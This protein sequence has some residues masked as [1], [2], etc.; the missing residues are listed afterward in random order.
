MIE[1]EAHPASGISDQA[2]QQSQDEAGAEP[3]AAQ[4]ELLELLK[5]HI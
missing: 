2:E 3:D 5:P 4:A 1:Q